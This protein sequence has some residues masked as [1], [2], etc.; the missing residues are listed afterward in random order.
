[1]NCLKALFIP[2][3]YGL[4]VRIPGSHPGGPGST[5]G[6]GI[7]F[8]TPKM[9]KVHCI[10]LFLKLQTHKPPWRNWLARSA[11]NRK[12]GGSSPPGGANFF[13]IFFF[14]LEKKLTLAGLEPAIP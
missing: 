8:W 5:P 13:T 12:V 14:N 11:V 6:V 1:M 3:R 4:V 9:N 10:H 7:P 2:I